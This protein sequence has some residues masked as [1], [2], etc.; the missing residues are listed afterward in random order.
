MLHYLVLLKK[1]ISFAVEN[2]FSIYLLPGSNAETAKRELA[3]KNEQNG[4]KF[5]ISSC[6]LRMFYK[7]TLN[8][9]TTY[10]EF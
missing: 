4:S 7:Y 5:N 2:K 1:K 3:K 8:T 6:Q 9:Y 10:I